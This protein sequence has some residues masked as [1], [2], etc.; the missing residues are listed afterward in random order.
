MYVRLYYVNINIQATLELV[1][2][3]TCIGP[4]HVPNIAETTYYH[5][6]IE[7]SHVSQSVGRLGSSHSN[8]AITL[9]LGS[10]IGIL[11]GL[12]CTP[13]STTYNLRRELHELT[14]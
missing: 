3:H 5:P 13:P 12:L 9:L 2:I 10:I 7:R 11:P 6:P 4:F 1:D 8:Q 14:A